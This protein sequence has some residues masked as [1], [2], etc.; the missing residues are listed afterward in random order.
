MLITGS[1]AM[2][3]ICLISVIKKLKA[4]QFWERSLLGGI[5]LALYRS[6]R[7]SDQ[8]MGKVMG[9]LLIGSLLC[10]TWICVPVVIILILF[11]VP[12]QVKKFKGICDGVEEIRSGNL[13]YEIPVEE[14]YKG[15]QGE[16]DRLAASINKISEAQKHALE[17]EMKSQRMKTDLIS[18][19]SHDLKTPLTSMVTY[20]DLLKTEGLDSPDAPEYLDIIDQK[21]RRLQVLTENLFD[22]AKASSGA[23]PVHMEAIDLSALVSQSLAE[24]E[25]KL[26]AR[27]LQVVVKNLCE[28][29]CH[30]MADG[31]LLWRVIE[32]L[33]SNV[34]KYALTGSRVYLNISR[35]PSGSDIEV[36]GAGND[37]ILF[38]VKN[39]SAE[40]LN[41]SAD[42][43][44]ERFK[45]GDES[46][47]TEGS[48]LGLAIAKDLVTLMHG[49]F[50][51]TVDGDLFKASVLLR[52]A[53]V[54]KSSE[55]MSV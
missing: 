44:M 33:L 10:A 4:H 28:N 43:L 47:N 42:E 39:I 7:G 51:L 12:K 34:S 25:E 2:T 22:A 41:I 29:N 11:F 32:N 1:V 31:Q 48:G 9:V 14:D 3:V 8:T 6:F 23:I 15:K 21:T 30:V 19:V 37:R 54:Q 13:N 55:Q 52:E 20:V 40:Q 24:M 46:R 45:R 16:F 5:W 17:E 18:N 26:N 35:V 38:E 53:A 36:G 50:V 27:Q 49:S